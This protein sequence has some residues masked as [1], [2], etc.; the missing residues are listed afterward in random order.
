MPSKR[1]AAPS[2]KQSHKK[3]KGASQ[4]G[5]ESRGYDNKLMKPSK[6][7]Q[8]VEPAFPNDEEPNLKNLLNRHVLTAGGVEGAT[9]IKLSFSSSAVKEQIT[10]PLLLDTDQITLPSQPVYLPT[11]LVRDVVPNEEFE[12]KFRKTGFVATQNIL[13]VPILSDEEQMEWLSDEDA[14]MKRMCTTEW[15]SD[16]KRT[17]WVC[18]GATRYTLANKYDMDLWA[19]FLRPDICFLSATLIAS[20]HNE[21]RC[22]AAVPL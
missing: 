18:D 8:T 10:L 21:G 12:Q 22:T 4:P 17:F 1:K 14:F 20:G 9:M 5:V 11:G 15:L 7:R 13:L 6:I 16:V 19:M 3:A 2:P